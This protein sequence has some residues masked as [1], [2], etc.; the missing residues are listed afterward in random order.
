MQNV[1]KV[2]HSRLR[3][4]AL[5]TPFHFVQTPE[6][7]LQ[8]W[9]FQ[10]VQGYPSWVPALG[11]YFRPHQG[12]ANRWQKGIGLTRNPRLRTPRGITMVMVHG[13]PRT[14]DHDPQIHEIG[15]PKII[16]LGP[17]FHGFGH[18]TH[19]AQLRKKRVT[20]NCVP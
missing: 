12:L 13:M 20:Q 7:G 19:F 14:P 15:T 6:F 2:R 8:N 5:F 4:F 18:F 16:N 3:F 9:C 11:P 17:F 1:P 10:R